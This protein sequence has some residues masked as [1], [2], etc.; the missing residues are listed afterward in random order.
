MVIFSYY[1]GILGW[2]FYDGYYYYYENWFWVCGSALIVVWIIKFVV[3]RGILSF[4]DKYE[5]V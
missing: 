3:S 4:K 2:N 1:K 5:F